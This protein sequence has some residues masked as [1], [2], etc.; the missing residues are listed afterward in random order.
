MCL[1]LQVFFIAP[2]ISRKH[3]KSFL[4]VLKKKKS[5]DSTS[6]LSTVT[7]CTET[8]QGFSFLPNWLVS[9]C[10][11]CPAHSPPTLQLC[12]WNPCFLDNMRDW[13]HVILSLCVT[14]HN[15]FQSVH[16]FTYDKNLFVWLFSIHDI[17]AI[18]FH[19][20]LIH[21]LLSCCFYFFNFLKILF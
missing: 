13:D 16:V 7:C 14:N 4:L 20:L 6:L 1:S 10:P 21:Y 19:Y 11:G 2:L 12:L 8:Q 5:P 15:D 3:L 9:L 17:A 18:Y